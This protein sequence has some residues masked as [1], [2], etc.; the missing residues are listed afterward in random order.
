MS[1]DQL[2]TRFKD[3][4]CFEM[5]LVM[6]EMRTR[7]GDIRQYRS[8]LV[9]ELGNDAGPRRLFAFRALREGFPEDR[10]RIRD[11]TPYEPAEKCREK[12]RRLHEAL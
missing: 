3:P 11:Y 7:G 6:A 1:L 9:E 4:N 8:Y 10:A 5:D 12:A 2:E